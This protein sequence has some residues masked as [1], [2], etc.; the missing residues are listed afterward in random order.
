M[1]TT[2]PTYLPTHLP[3]AI[4]S[5]SPTTPTA[6]NCTQAVLWQT[7]V[8]ISMAILPWAIHF[9]VWAFTSP[10]FVLREYVVTAWLASLLWFFAILWF[11]LSPQNM[12]VNCLG[13]VANL[14]INNTQSQLG[15]VAV[16]LS[17][18]Y[19]ILFGIYVMFGWVPS[20]PRFIKT[21]WTVVRRP[22]APVEPVAATARKLVET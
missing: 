20:Q 4:P 7:A 19:E 6:Y 13:Y 5:Q 1:T 12:T 14:T 18:I 3:T 2:A 11:A 15:L 9:L 16:I 8:A 10:K 21:G 22:A 17:A